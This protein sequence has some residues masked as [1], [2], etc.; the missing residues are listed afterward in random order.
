M[1]FYVMFIFKTRALL[2]MRAAAS[3]ISCFGQKITIFL[4]VLGFGDIR[5]RVAFSPKISKK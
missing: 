5:W 3:K 1:G 2:Q 4:K